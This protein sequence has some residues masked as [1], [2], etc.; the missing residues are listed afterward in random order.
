[1]RQLVCLA[2]TLCFLCFALPSLAADN[3]VAEPGELIAT[4]VQVT[5][6][7]DDTEAKE[8]PLLLY[9]PRDYSADKKWPLVL[10]LHGLGESG[11]GGEELERVKIHGPCKQISEGKHFPFVVVAPQN[12]RPGS[13]EE[14]KKAWPPELLASLLD[15]AE[16]DL[17]ID[18]DRI[19]VTGLS[20]GGFGSWNLACAYPDRLAAVAPICGGGDVT[21]VT[22]TMAQTPVWAFHGDNDDVVPVEQSIKMVEALRA[23]GGN[24][25]LTTYPGVN[26]G[27][28]EQTYDNPMFYDWLL[29]C[30]RAPN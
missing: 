22:E 21:K 26:H 1:M 27:S 13:Y 20:M 30:K 24:V 25:R 16:S 15:R 14:V 17:A 4:S 7:G 9:T 12:P 23:V 6:A 8:V 29:G 10:F 2:L 18:S 11:E 3:L 19:Y 28:W 5:P